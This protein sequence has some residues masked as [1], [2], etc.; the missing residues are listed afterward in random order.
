MTAP[1][2]E[3]IK[4]REV[5]ERH[6]LPENDR[7][8]RDIEV[9]KID[10]KKHAYTDQTGM[11]HPGYVVQEQRIVHVTG[12]FPQ[13]EYYGEKWYED[14]GVIA[15]DDMGALYVAKRNLVDYVTGGLYFI[16]EATGE[17]WQEARTTTKGVVDT[18]GNP[19]THLLERKAK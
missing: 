18:E 9:W 4:S 7:R 3:E 10:F 11:V 17:Y 5:N 16:N 19:I 12:T 6:D 2:T 8:R 13:Y 15:H 1:T 14:V